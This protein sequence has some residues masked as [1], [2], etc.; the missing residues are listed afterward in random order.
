MHSKRDSMPQWSCLPRRSVRYVLPWVRCKVALCDAHLPVESSSDAMT[1]RT[2]NKS[3]AVRPTRAVVRA[4]S[5]TPSAIVVPHLETS[6]DASQEVGTRNHLTYTDEHQAADE[7]AQFPGVLAWIAMWT[8]PIALLVVGLYLVIAFPPIAGIGNVQ[9]Q[10]NPTAPV[11]D[12]SQM[13]TPTL[14]LTVVPSITPNAFAT[15]TVAP[16]VAATA[17]EQ[18]TVAPTATATPKHKP[19]PTP[20]AIATV[21]A[22]AT[23][24]P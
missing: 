20:T 23:I 17:T 6:V 9:A 19:T 15:A 24:I 11:L 5:R 12:P 3:S 21:T 18:P 8:L 10:P 7:V 4:G 22:T 2:D 14:N 1:P 13:M 16:S